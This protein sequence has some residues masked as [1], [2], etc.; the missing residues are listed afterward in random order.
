[1][2]ISASTQ[3]LA[4]DC[5]SDCA[6]IGKGFT[7]DV[8]AWDEGRVLKLFY[9][10]RPLAKIEQ[11]YK[12][13]R[14]VQAAGLPVPNVY[15][16]VEIAGRHGIVLERVEGVSLFKQV[17][18]RPWRL[19]AA[20]RQLAELHAQIHACRAPAELPSQREWIA[21]RI[22]AAADLTAEKKD[23]ARRRLAELPDG[24]TLCHGDFHPENVFI[25]SRGPVIIDWSTA[26]RGDP[27]GDVACTSWLF[28]H[29][30][31]PAWVPRSM[32]LL[33][34]VSRARLHETYLNRYFQLRRGTRRDIEAWRAPLCIALAGW[35]IDG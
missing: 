7:S 22:E 26:T 28:Q 29:A 3:Q 32:H 17:Q 33:L 8:Y 15:E 24:Q 16:L 31:L 19:F 5:L 10:E 27:L 13:A 9:P 23:E 11:E 2:T 34:A 6:I 12:V 4:A 18:A 21:R 20:V 30:Q 14:A 1:M 25:T 35:R